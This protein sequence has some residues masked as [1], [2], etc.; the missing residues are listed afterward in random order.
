MYNFVSRPLTLFFDFIKDRSGLAVVESA[1]FIPLLLFAALAVFDFGRAGVSQMEMQQALR[2]GAQVSMININDED[3]VVAATLAALGEITAG[4]SAQDGL[5]Q[6]DKTCID[7]LFQC[8][9][10]STGVT[11]CSTI[12]AAT[13]E[14]PST[15]L[16]ILTSRRHDGILVPDFEINNSIV[17]QTR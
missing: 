9:C 2:A 5:C 12:C 10:E 8:E 16:S 1:F 4:S 14:P 13:N 3:E 11:G 17:I 6:V 7:V 15:F